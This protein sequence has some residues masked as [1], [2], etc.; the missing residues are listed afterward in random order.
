[1]RVSK[2]GGVRAVHR[3]SLD[4]YSPLAETDPKTISAKLWHES[5][6]FTLRVYAHAVE[7]LHRKDANALDSLMAVDDSQTYAAKE[8]QRAAAR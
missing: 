1:M 8:S 7:T 4:A 3:T 5:P 6:A 2:H